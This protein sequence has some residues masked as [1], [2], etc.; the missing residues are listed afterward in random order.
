MDIITLSFKKLFRSRLIIGYPITSK[1]IIISDTLTL[2][3][4]VPYHLTTKEKCI[5]PLMQSCKCIL[6]KTCQFSP[7][8]T[9]A[10]K[11]IFYVQ[12]LFLMLLIAYY[13]S[14]IVY[15]LH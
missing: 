14:V 6:L 4:E 3:V 5:S 10:T 8:S 11:M 12:T 7:V 9:F 1:Q 13:L 2:A 15:T